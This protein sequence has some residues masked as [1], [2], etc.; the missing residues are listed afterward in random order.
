MKNI[1][2]FLFFV[3]ALNAFSQENVCRKNVLNTDAVF[4]KNEI[5]KY[6]K[7]DFS[8]LWTQ[9]ENNLIY[10]VIGNQYQRILIKFI[11]IKKDAKN[12]NE[13]I[14]YGK[15]Q[16]KSNTCDF[17]GKIT[18]IKIQELKKLQFGVDDEYKDKG[19]KSQSLLTASYKFIENS[20]QK[21]TGEF[22]G[23]LQTIWYLDKNNGIKYNDIEKDSDSYINN[24][25]VGVWKSNVSKKEKICNWGDYR[26]PN[27]NCDFDIGTGELSI[28]KKYLKN[29]WEIKSQTKWW[30]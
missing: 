20:L 6:Q 30:K 22:Q 23:T 18:I 4:Q 25:F 1:S 15:S 11:S 10:G 26:V 21:D 14:V 29:G 8:S 5:D 27:V 28:S 9:T 2:L 24:A 3:I 7:Y 16:V 13:Y 19:I 12:P 17:V